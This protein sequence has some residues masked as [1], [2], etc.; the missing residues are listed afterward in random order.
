MFLQS[1]IQVCAGN[2]RHYT[3]SEYISRDVSDCRKD[4]PDLS[5]SAGMILRRAQMI[6]SLIL[7]F[8]EL[9]LIRGNAARWSVRRRNWQCF[10]LMEIERL[11]WRFSRNFLQLRSRYRLKLRCTVLNIRSN[12]LRLHRASVRHTNLPESRDSLQSNI[13]RTEN[14]WHSFPYKPLVKLNG[15][16]KALTVS[17]MFCSHPVLFAFAQEFIS[18]GTSP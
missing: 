15:L 4:M 1:L 5:E 6:H 9:R 13:I 18:S 14:V 2:V 10:A 17:F 12:R 7:Q 3:R 8:R 11:D 16:E